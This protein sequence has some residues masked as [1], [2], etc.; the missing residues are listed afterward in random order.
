LLCDRSIKARINTGEIG[1]E[2]APDLEGPQL[3]PASLDL[4]LGGKFILRSPSGDF[5]LD[6]TKGEPVSIYPGECLLART[7]ETVT[8][9][10]YLA[11]RVEG[12][13]TWGRQFLSIHSTA[14]F[15]DPGFHGTITLELKNE[16]KRIVFIHPG[17]FICQLSFE[18]L[19]EEAERK[20]GDKALRSHYWGQEEPTL[21]H[22]EA[23]G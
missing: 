2:P 13:S 6:V 19:D 17:D 10:G 8:L 5:T 9:P 7:E 18:Q 23:M 11:A 4:R 22:S 21:P 12:K 14:G 16:G 1:I 20:Y 3:Q 15:I